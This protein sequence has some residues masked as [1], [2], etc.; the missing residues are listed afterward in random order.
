MLP[1]FQSSRP[2]LYQQED[3]GMFIPQ[4]VGTRPEAKS[5]Y[6]KLSCVINQATIHLFPPNRYS[7]RPWML[8]G[9]INLKIRHLHGL[10][11]TYHHTALHA[12]LFF[13][14]NH[15]IFQQQFRV[16]R[17]YCNIHDL[18]GYLTWL[19]DL[20]NYSSSI[21]SIFSALLNW[22][23]LIDLSTEHILVYAVLNCS[24]IWRYLTRISLQMASQSY[25]FIVV[26]CEQLVA[27]M[28]DTHASCIFN[29]V[30]C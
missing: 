6:I 7:T 17:G 24:N 2:P 11:G 10:V 15:R 5:S 3:R 26:G 13:V 21:N 27:L 14:C 12:F 16:S 8:I 20:L 22:F 19:Q 4:L 23:P 9:T 25:D 29:R 28:H 1:S 18:E 30:N